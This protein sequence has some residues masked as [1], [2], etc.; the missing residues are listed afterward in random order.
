MQDD[1]RRWLWGPATDLLLGCGLAYAAVFVA[2]LFVGR[3]MQAWIPLGLLP[4]G[5][6]LLGTPHYGATILR[7]YDRRQDRQRYWLFTVYATAFIFAVFLVGLHVP[8]LGSI[9]YTLYLTWSPW[10]YAG[11]N[12]GLAAMFL[13]RRGVEV[14]PSARHALYGSF[15]LSFVLA[16]LVIHD[17]VAAGS[18]YGPTGAA[19]HGYE[20]IP[21][22]LPAVFSAYVT[23]AVLLGYVACVASAAVQLKRKASWAD[24]APAA[25]LVGSQALWFLVPAVVRGTGLG[26]DLVPLA[27][28]D[29]QYA[30]WWI[31]FAHS[32]QYLWVTSYY[33]TVET[34]SRPAGF[35]LRAFLAGSALWG[36]PALVFATAHLGPLA[37]DQGLLILIASCVNLHHFVLDGAIWKLRDGPVA[38]ILLRGENTDVTAPSEPPGPSWTRALVWSLGAI[39]A[40]QFV[41]YTL[42]QE[43]GVRRATERGD[44]ARLEKATQRFA[45]IGLETPNAPLNQGILYAQRGH[46]REARRSL[47]LSLDLQPTATAYTALGQ[48]HAREG[49][50]AASLA[51]LESALEL[52]P[53]NTTALHQMGAT[54][55]RLGRPGEAVK[56][57]TRARSSAAGQP[58]TQEIDRMLERARREV[59]EAG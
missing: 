47:E 16:F 35:L 26:Q 9:T 30:F 15:V 34:G 57:L 38:R 56:A 18:A 53:Q 12:F 10:H 21:L 59:D 58:G 1:T 28:A 20:F 50:L 19:P 22:G 52:D 4:L 2:M 3:E 40:I 31:V 55:L 36:V 13:R 37:Y 7:A 11:Q 54:W 44:T 27:L 29:A 43:F 24:L 39:C 46:F 51:A 42:E 23:V 17:T 6:L 45:W 41:A 32:V 49:D 25:A 33:A 48:V 14:T 5:S 8:L